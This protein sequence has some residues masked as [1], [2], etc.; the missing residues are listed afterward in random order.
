MKNTV[1]KYIGWNMDQSPETVLLNMPEWRMDRIAEGIYAVGV[2]SE[3]S[4]LTRRQEILPPF[5]GSGGSLWK[6]FL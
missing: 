1:L 5:A 6:G 3:F 4:L 2:T